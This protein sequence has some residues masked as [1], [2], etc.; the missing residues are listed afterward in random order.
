VVIAAA[1]AALA[2]IA[3]VDVIKVDHAATIAAAENLVLAASPVH[4]ANR[5][6]PANKPTIHT[7]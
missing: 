7:K 5:V 2:S 1:L 3:A 6:R 4:K